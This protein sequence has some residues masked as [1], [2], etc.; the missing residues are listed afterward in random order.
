MATLTD[1]TAVAVY[2]SSV[3]LQGGHVINLTCTCASAHVCMFTCTPK[4]CVARA[5][6]SS[7]IIYFSFAGVGHRLKV[8]VSGLSMPSIYDLPFQDKIHGIEMMSNGGGGQFYIYGGRYLALCIIHPE[9]N[10]QLEILSHCKLADCISSVSANPSSSKALHLVTTYNVAVE[11]IVD[12]RASFVISRKSVCERSTLYCSHMRQSEDGQWT[13]LMIFGGTALGEVLI[14]Q[15]TNG[16]NSRISY[17][18]SAPRASSR[19]LYHRLTM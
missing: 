13:G 9:N 19:S 2:N 5:R 3:V 16:G 4:F 6:T 11:I 18:F 12:E 1:S 7:F 10:H 17:R 8:F 14:W 15:P